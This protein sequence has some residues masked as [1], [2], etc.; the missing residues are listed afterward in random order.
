L[1]GLPYLPEANG[2]TIRSFSINPNMLHYRLADSLLLFVR[3]N[4]GNQYDFLAVSF[5]LLS[6]GRLDD[7]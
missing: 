7:R 1:R 2:G 6:D 4:S 3:E 5:M